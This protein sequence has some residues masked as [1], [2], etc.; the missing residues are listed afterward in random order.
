MRPYCN[1]KDAGARSIAEVDVHR[2][3]ADSTPG[4][5][6]AKA[7]QIKRAA[8]QDARRV[9]ISTKKIAAGLKK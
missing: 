4:W 3:T 2:K 1:D 5:R 6:R 7:R 9:L 8:R